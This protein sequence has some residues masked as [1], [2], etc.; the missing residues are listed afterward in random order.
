MTI[1]SNPF[2]ILNENSTEVPFKKSKIKIHYTMNGDDQAGK[3]D[4]RAKIYASNGEYNSY[5]INFNNDTI[6]VDPNLT[7]VRKV[8]GSEIEDLLRGVT[9]FGKEEILVLVDGK[10]NPNMDKTEAARLVKSLGKRYDKL[11]K[12]EKEKYIQSIVIVDK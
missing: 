10:R 1:Y 9:A 12:A 7:K 5:P 6:T 2:S 3:H 11:S 8:R 4:L